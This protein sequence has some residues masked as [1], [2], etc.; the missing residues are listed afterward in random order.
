[1]E[2]ISDKEILELLE[3]TTQYEKGFRALMRKYQEPIYWH[4][5]RMVENHEDT[6]DIVQNTFI[7]V[8]KGIKNFKQNSKLYTW[9]YRIATNET[10]TFINKKKKQKSTSI[11]DENG[12]ENRLMADN[13]SDSDEI[14]KHLKRAIQ[15][16]P[17]RQKLV[18]NM[19]YYD[20]MSYQQISEVLETSV[21]SLKASYHHAVKK[22]EHYFV[23]NER[24]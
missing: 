23:A 5:R 11:D 18:F 20:E 9:L 12:I 14:L 3:H 8:Y 7:K 10:I 19:R 1:M 4:I 2:Q 24:Q 6:N 13:Y 21:G 16:L 22:I 15:T 17:D